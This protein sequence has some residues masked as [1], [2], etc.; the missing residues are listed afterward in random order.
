[1]RDLGREATFFADAYRLFNAIDNVRGLIAHMRDVDAAHASD[2]LRDLDDFFG[3]GVIAGHV[4]EAGGETEGAIPHR[5]RSERFHLFDLFW[6]GFAIGESD[7]L[8]DRD[9]EI[10]GSL[11]VA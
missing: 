2:D 11:A 10:Q 9:C 4:I 5:L 8:A 3:W 7:D 1:M 6:S